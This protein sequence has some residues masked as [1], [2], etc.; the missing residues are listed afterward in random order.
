[1]PRWLPKTDITRFTEKLE[2]GDV[3]FDKGLETPCWIWT[4][5]I[6]HT[7]YMW[8]DEISGLTFNSNFYS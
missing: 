8:L 5:L 3:P 4:V 6:H 7:Y 1:M 2:I